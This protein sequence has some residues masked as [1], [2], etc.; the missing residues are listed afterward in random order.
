M[1]TLFLE[2]NLVGNPVETSG[3]DGFCQPGCLIRIVALLVPGPVLHLPCR[4]CSAPRMLIIK[5][6]I[7]VSFADFVSRISIV[8]D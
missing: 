5:Q 1:L 6:Y 2:I 8:A 4:I 3:Q 7:I